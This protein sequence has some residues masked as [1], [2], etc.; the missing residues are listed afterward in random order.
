MGAMFAAD[1]LALYV[2]IDS[3]LAAAVMS[4]IVGGVV[5]GKAKVDELNGSKKNTEL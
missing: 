4:I 3:W 5:Y 1:Q 2:E